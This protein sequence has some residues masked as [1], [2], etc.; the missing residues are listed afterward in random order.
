MRGSINGN[1][2]WATDGLRLSILEF[3]IVKHDLPWRAKLQCHGAFN[4]QTEL[5]LG[6]NPA[7]E[8]ESDEFDIQAFHWPASKLVV[9]AGD[10]AAIAVREVDGVVVDRGLLTF[11]YQNSLDFCRFLLSPSGRRLLVF[12]SRAAIVFEFDGR[13]ILNSE[14][15]G[16]VRDAQWRIDSEIDVRVL[17]L[18]TEP[19]E[20]TRTWRVS[21]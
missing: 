20:V 5:D 13:A 11:T 15:Y 17:E 8:H 3:M 21:T 7:S 19:T 18:H 16:L 6:P 2:E 1:R 9:F 4:W 12:S 10:G 14:I